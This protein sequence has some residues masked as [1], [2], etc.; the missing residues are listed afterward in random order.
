MTLY[1]AFNTREPYEST[2]L[3]GVFDTYD[4]AKRAWLK[5]HPYVSEKEFYFHAECIQTV[6]LNTL[7]R[8]ANDNIAYQQTRS[9]P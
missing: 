1:I 8:C 3:I 9:K 7:T 4:E 2:Y 6:S 5:V